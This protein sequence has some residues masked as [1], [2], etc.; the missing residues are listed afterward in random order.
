MYGTLFK[1]APTPARIGKSEALLGADDEYVH[2]KVFGLSNDGIDEL[3][4][5]QVIFSVLHEISLNERRAEIF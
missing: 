4:N 1:L 2:G 3:M 5:E